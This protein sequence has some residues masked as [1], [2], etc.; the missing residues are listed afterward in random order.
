MSA[1]V[2]KESPWGALAQLSAE[3]DEGRRGVVLVTLDERAEMR[4]TC[5]GQVSRAE[6]ALIGALITQHAIEDQ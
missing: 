4:W 1:I 2:N 5:C 6:L 3:L